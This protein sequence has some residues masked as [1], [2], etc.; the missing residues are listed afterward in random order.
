MP[1]SILDDIGFSNEQSPADNTA[2]GDPAVWTLL[3]EAGKDP[4]GQL[5]VASTIANRAN[6]AKTD[7]GQ[8]VTDP[9]QGYEAWQDSKARAQTQQSYP[10]GSDAYNQAAEVLSNLKSGKVQPLSYTHFQ[11]PTGQAAK[12]RSEPD[13]AKGLTGTDIG[14]NRFYTISSKTAGSVLDSQGFGNTPAP[15]VDPR[16]A[17][18]LAI[19]SEAS[20]DNPNFPVYDPYNHVMRNADGSVAALGGDPSIAAK[21]AKQDATDDMAQPEQGKHLTIGAGADTNPDRIKAWLATNPNDIANSK[22]PVGAATPE[23]APG[24]VGVDQSFADVKNSIEG[25]AAPFSQGAR[26]DLVQGLINRQTNDQNLGNN[27]DYG[28]GKFIGGVASTAPILAI[29]G[30][31]ELGEGA[32][33]GSKFAPAANFL[34]GN[35][36]GNPLIRGLSMGAKGLA[37]GAE[38]GFLTNAGNN[39]SMAQNVGLG[40]ASGLVLNPLVEGGSNAVGNLLT[41][42]PTAGVTPAVAG[43]AKTA[44]D[45]Y[46]IPLR[47]TQIKGVGNRAIATADSELIGSDANHAANNAAQKTAFTRAVAKTFGSDADQLTPNVMDAAKDRIGGVMN[48]IGSRTDITNTNGLLTNLHSIVSEASQVVPDAELKPLLNQIK[49]IS[50][51]IQ[52]DSTSAGGERLSGK[53]YA[54]LIAK[55]SPL[56][57]ATISKNSDIRQYAQKIRNVLDDAVEAEASPEDVTALKQARFQYKNMMTVK[58]LAAKANVEGEINPNLLNGAVNTNFKQRAFQGAGDLGELAQIGQTFMKE[59]P[60]SFTADRTFDR[61]KKLMPGLTVAGGV[62]AGLALSH[63]ILAAQV[64]GGALGAATLKGGSN[65]VRNASNLSPTVRNNF[66]DNVLKGNSGIPSATR[67]NPLVPAGAIFTNN[68]FAPPPQQKGSK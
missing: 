54:S 45:K 46:G 64:A 1:N 10:V 30:L 50:D 33:A 42:G 14:G 20:Q 67:V 47:I 58:N 51:T 24:A 4:Q 36:V 37:Q 27:P 31:G 32:L 48:D 63:P 23:G 65:L 62:D 3:G 59:P 11:S 8:I 9:S 22:I 2:G 6:T 16:E 53:S 25:L 17:A 35:A 57:N 12:G 28:L 29:P 56:D 40:A 38:T 41:G 39:N 34:G 5:A 15:T 61:L 18:Q 44:T 26:N 52:G 66:L 21:A 55:G 19:D 13:W 68:M 43:L 60:N 7:Y 49:N